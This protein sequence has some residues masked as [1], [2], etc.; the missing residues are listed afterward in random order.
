MGGTRIGSVERNRSENRVLWYR[1]GETAPLRHWGGRIKDTFLPKRVSY[2][3]TRYGAEVNFYG[4]RYET[5]LGCYYGLQRVLAQKQGLGK[6]G[7][8]K[9]LSRRPAFAE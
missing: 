1:K 8:A 5:I 4:K 3:R 6:A 7:Q 2:Y 9:S